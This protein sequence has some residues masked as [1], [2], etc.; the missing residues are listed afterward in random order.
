M[1]LGSRK[2]RL[3][4]VLERQSR[5]PRGGSR[6]ALLVQWVQEDVE[7][8]TSHTLFSFHVQFYEHPME[9]PQLRHL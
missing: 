2:E 5:A 8:I 1:L 4:T 3:S 6:G 9:L 7:S